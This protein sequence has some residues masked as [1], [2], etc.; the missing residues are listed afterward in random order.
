MS[1]GS[2]NIPWAL[3]ESLSYSSKVARN[4][5][6]WHGFCRQHKYLKP[7][8]AS[9]ISLI[10]GKG[11]DWKPAS[12]FKFWVSGEQKKVPKVAWLRTEIA[13][14]NIEID[15]VLPKLDDEELF[16][17]QNSAFIQFDRQMAAHMA[18]SLVSHNKAGRMS[19]R[20]LEVAPHE[21]IWPNMGVTSLGRFIRVC[22]I[23][24]MLENRVS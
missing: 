7:S 1:L 18:C 21:I 4:R 22:R 8:T 11:G 17:K 9:Q 12:S 3:H 14:L 5:K 2:R 19:P 13:R 16:K 6:C 24:L 20:F 23:G 10:K 15:E